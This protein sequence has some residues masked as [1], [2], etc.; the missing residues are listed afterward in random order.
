MQSYLIYNLNFMNRH[1]CE[2]QE[3]E[4]PGEKGKKI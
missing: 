3:K 4:H 2:E 1:P